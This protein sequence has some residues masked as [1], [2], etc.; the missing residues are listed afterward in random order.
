M[1]GLSTALFMV[2]M[3]LLL[4]AVLVP[5]FLLINSTPAYSSQGEGQ[6]QVY[7]QLQEEQ[8]N[9][10]YRGN[11]NIYYNSSTIPHI[12]FQ[13]V[14]LPAPLNVTQVYYFSPSSASWVPVLKN[15]LVIAS[16][17]TLALPVQAFNNP[18]LIATSEG[19]MFFLN[20][21]TSVVSVNLV[22]PSGKVPLYVTAFVINGSKAYPVSLQF[23]L[24]TSLE[25]FTPT[26]L[27]LLPGSYSIA[28]KNSTT[29][30]LPQF[31]LTAT[32]Q[33]WSLV[34]DGYFTSS[35]DSPATSFNIYGPLVLTIVY[36]ALTQKF[37]VT[38]MPN[39]IPLGS[40]IQGNGGATLTSMNNTIPVYVDNK[41]YEVG[42]TG[43]TLTLTEGYHVIEFPTEYNI[44]FDY[45]NP[46]SL[47]TLFQN[48]PG[49]E[50]I[51][52]NFTGLSTSSSEIKVSGEYLVFVNASGIVYGN[53]VQSWTYYEVLVK[54]DFFLPSN[55]ELVKNSTPVLGDIGGQLLCVQ[56]GNTEYTWGPVNNFNVSKLYLKQGTQVNY[57][58]DLLY[59]LNGTF[60]L[61]IGGS[62]VT[63][64]QLL[65]YPVNVTCI[66]PNNSGVFSSLTV[67]SPILLINYEEWEWY[68][69]PP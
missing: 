16:N 5:A 11:P 24:G 60:V 15:N 56:I 18:V 62:E 31:G 2:L 34:G 32:F 22:G 53:Y 8:V 64:Y 48:L 25:Y 66:E 26:I 55:V 7:T 41:L 29:I 57:R 52:Y 9:Q 44:T 39:G 50:I 59:G 40:T 61:E 51:T 27:D 65:S 69:V 6:A 38:I 47:Y 67:Y 46:T 19:N 54:N 28:D 17:F 23:V 14:N 1:K 4:F 58:G 45:Q 13:Y 10:V 68:G 36:K 37:S 63:A 42:A 3:L 21:N 30:Y 33:N 49:G 12:V 35:S 20:P 43:I